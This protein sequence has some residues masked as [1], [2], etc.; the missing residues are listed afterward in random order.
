MSIALIGNTGS[1][2]PC[3]RSTLRTGFAAAEARLT[4][5]EYPNEPQT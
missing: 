4:E 3:T 1:G 2:S 5:R